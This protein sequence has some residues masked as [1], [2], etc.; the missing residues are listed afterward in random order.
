MP[1]LVQE[2]VY[3]LAYSNTKNSADPL[4]YKT[5]QC[6]L[7]QFLYYKEN[8]MP[9]NLL[10]F[11]LCHH[12]QSNHKSQIFHYDKINKPSRSKNNCF[13]EPIGMKNTW[14]PPI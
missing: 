2:A 7:H 12:Y 3:F 10:F 11:F 8:I 13:R 4:F 6:V 14:D 5:L 1:L 9:I